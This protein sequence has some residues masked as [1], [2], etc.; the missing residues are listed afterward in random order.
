MTFYL[1]V[2]YNDAGSPT[3]INRV[4]NASL[5]R[6]NTVSSS[7]TSKQFSGTV[8]YELLSSK[9]LY[10]QVNGDFYNNGSTTVSGGASIK[11][12]EYG[13]LNFSSSIT[14]SHYSYC[15]FEDLMELK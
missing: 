13:T 6:N 2:V 11:V 1:E 14:K 7:I 10:F 9:Q 4:V 12:G 3:D 5:N 15:W 8:F